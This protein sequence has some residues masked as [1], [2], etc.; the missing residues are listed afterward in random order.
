[1]TA[2]SAIR[3]L[4]GAA[5]NFKSGGRALARTNQLDRRNQLARRTGLA[6]QP[7]PIF[8]AP[9]GSPG[10]KQVKNRAA[11]SPIPQ[12]P[13]PDRLALPEGR[14]ATP[15]GAQPT[16]SGEPLGQSLTDRL[17]GVVRRHPVLTGLAAAD[18]G[19]LAAN[20]VVGAMV[21]PDV[22]DE[23][24]AFLRERSDRLADLMRAER[25]QRD[26][27]RNVQVL[28]SV[29]PDLYNQ[30]VAGRRLPR[31]TTVIGGGQSS[32]ALS[33]VALMMSRGAFSPG[34]TVEEQLS[35]RY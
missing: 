4:T 27:A 20:P 15:S 18:V 35:G 29:D 12:G 3:F 7:G 31:G 5:K 8:D 23:K 13:A 33:Q 14:S 30:L 21:G 19:L 2:G 16:G 26:M 1:M 22:R 17:F 34:P 10:R 11:G 9:V 32:E 25:L 28:A 24:Q 6:R